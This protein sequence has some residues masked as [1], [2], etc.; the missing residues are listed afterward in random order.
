MV[1]AIGMK[2]WIELREAPVPPKAKTTKSSKIIIKTVKKRDWDTGKT[3][4]QHIRTRI[5]FVATIF[6]GGKVI[7]TVT[8]THFYNVTSISLHPKMVTALKAEQAKKLLETSWKGNKAQPR[9]RAN[10]DYRDGVLVHYTIAD[11]DGPF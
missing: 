7:T 10:T 3:K 1:Y 6:E 11:D 4:I 5:N 8:P 2:G 9:R